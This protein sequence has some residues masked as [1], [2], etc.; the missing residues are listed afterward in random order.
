MGKSPEDYPRDIRITKIEQVRLEVDRPEI[1]SNSRV[2]EIIYPEPNW[3]WEE[4]IIRIHNSDGDAGMGRRT[5]GRGSRAARPESQ[6]FRS[7]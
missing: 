4:G 1:G 3:K 2:E 5:R 6:P 7:A